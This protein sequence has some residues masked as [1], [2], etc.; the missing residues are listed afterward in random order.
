VLR[1]FANTE[2]STNPILNYVYQSECA[3]L[4]AHERHWVSPHRWRHDVHTHPGRFVVLRFG[5][6]TP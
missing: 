6:L 3:D 5:K 4:R 1:W 2:R